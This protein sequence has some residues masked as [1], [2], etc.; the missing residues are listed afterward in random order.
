MIF[1]F[2]F[3]FSLLA[4]FVANAAMDNPSWVFGGQEILEKALQVKGRFQGHP[5]ARYEHSLELV[6]KLTKDFESIL[7]LTTE[8]GQQ[9]K[10]GN[11]QQTFGL[12]VEAE[13][14]T[15]DVASL[16]SLGV[17][18]ALDT[19]EI[20][21]AVLQF[22]E[23]KEL[24]NVLELMGSASDSVAAKAIANS[25]T[26]RVQEQSVT[27][28]PYFTFS[29]RSGSLGVKTLLD[30]FVLHDV[31]PVVIP[32]Q[33]ASVHGGLVKGNFSFVLHD[34]AHGLLYAKA[35]RG[36]ALAKQLPKIRE[37]IRSLSGS[38]RASQ[39]KIVQNHIL[40]HEATVFLKDE[41]RAIL[42]TPQDLAGHAI[43]EMNLATGTE[44]DLKIDQLSYSLA[45]ILNFTPVYLDILRGMGVDGKG[46]QTK[47]LSAEKICFIF[48]EK[49]LPAKEVQ[50]IWTH[51]IP[52][53]LKYSF[54][55]D[56]AKNEGGTYHLTSGDEVGSLEA[57]FQNV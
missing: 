51:P 45:S 49:E 36:T 10:L 25:V 47:I 14:V 53:I 56:L 42:K 57:L 5:E 21:P 46:I 18:H 19:E 31:I 27:M 7:S 9:G 13:S 32:A 20:S 54:E 6:E 34:Y 55:V 12:F 4:S 8:P 3:L 43:G 2:V 35:M 44:E 30:A 33:S 15:W 48:S 22:D 28:L 38:D 26:Q 39:I 11:L 23:A 24:I 40:F 17:A 50:V 52:E 16:F 29:K 1:K 37:E 41:D